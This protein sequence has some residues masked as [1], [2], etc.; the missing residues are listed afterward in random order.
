VEVAARP[1]DNHLYLRVHHR[2]G[3]PVS[4]WLLSDGTL[5]MLVLTLLPYLVV[6]ENVYLI[7]EPENGVHPRAIE[8]IHDSL[9]SVYDNQVLLATHSPLVLG[10]SQP[11]E[12]L[13]FTRTEDGAA[14]VVRGSEHPRLRDWQGEVDLA[15]LYAA[16]VLS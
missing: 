2:G 12:L 14:V 5:R 8:A 1:E 4:S 7:E 6:K 15:T 9:S 3:D 16:G 10:R 11:D 13:C